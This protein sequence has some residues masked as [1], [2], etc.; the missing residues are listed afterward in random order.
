MKSAALKKPLAESPRSEEEEK[1]PHPS[2]R[3]SLDEWDAEQK[4][5][6]FGTRDITPA[7]EVN[8]H[9]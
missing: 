1:P 3:P 2:A 5:A 4:E 8:A 9:K 6:T 7:D